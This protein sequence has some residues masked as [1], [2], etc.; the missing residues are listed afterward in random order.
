MDR[1]LDT[2]RQQVSGE[3]QAGGFPTRSF[4]TLNAENFLAT[5]FDEFRDALQDRP[6]AALFNG[7]ITLIK[8]QTKEFIQEHIQDV[9][10]PRVLGA[11]WASLPVEFRKDQEFISATFARPYE[12]TRMQSGFE[13]VNKMAEHF[14]LWR[15]R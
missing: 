12:A 6:I 10:A 4:V 8:E 3:P 13:Y 7:F 5:A 1:T 14:D 9:L 11:E 15:E 2:L